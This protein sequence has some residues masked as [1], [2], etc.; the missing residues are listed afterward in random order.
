MLDNINRLF[1]TLIAIL[2]SHQDSN[3]LK[4]I[5]YLNIK[6]HL[7]SAVFGKESSPPAKKPGILG[8]SCRWPR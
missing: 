5:N 2:L 1:A 4:E 3:E 7:I 6:I 8:V